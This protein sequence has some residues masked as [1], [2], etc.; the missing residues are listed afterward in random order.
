MKPRVRHSP[1]AAAMLVAAAASA[2]TVRILPQ[3]DSAPIAFAAD[4]IATAVEA[5]GAKVLIGTGGM[6][7]GATIIHLEAPGPETTQPAEAQPPPAIPPNQPE[8]F[9]IFRDKTV[10]PPLELWA[11]G[12]D[13]RGAM[14]AGLE[15][16]EHIALYGLP[17]DGSLPDLSRRAQPSLD[18]RC[19][20]LNMPLPGTRYLGDEWAQHNDWFWDMHYW[21]EFLNMLARNRYNALSLWSAHP[22]PQMVK[23]SK[24][25]EAA[26]LSDDDLAKNQEFFHAILRM[27]GDRGIDTYLVTWNIHVS[28][29]FAE[30]HGI[31][32]AGQDSP[33]VRDYQK[34]CVRELLVQYPEL[35]GIGTCPGENMPM[36]AAEREQWIRD[37]YVKGIEESGRSVPFLHRYW[38]G[39]A[40]PTQEIVAANYEGP[41]YVTLK[42][43]GEHMYSSPEPHFVDEAWTDQVPR[44]Y[45]IVWHL[46]NDDIYALRWG[47]PDFARA[48]LQNCQD[49]YATG[50]LIGSEIWLPGEDYIHTPEAAKHKTWD[51]DFEKQWCRFMLWGRLGYDLTTPMEVFKRHFQVRFGDAAGEQAFEALREASKIAPLVTA[52]HWNYMNGDWYPEGNVGPWNTGAGRGKNWRLTGEGAGDTA[53]FHDVL[54]WMFN[55]TIDDGFVDIPEYT[56]EML[57]LRGQPAPRGTGRIYPP[58]VADLLDQHAAAALQRA[59]A[60]AT[61]ASADNKEFECLN[62]DL[63]AWGVLGHYYAAKIRGACSL[64]WFIASGEQQDQAEAIRH[65]TEALAWWKKLVRVTKRHY[66]PHEV[67]LFGEFD[68]ER[69]L[70]E[71]ERD[72][73]IARTIEPAP[74]EVEKSGFLLPSGE[75][76][77]AFNAA[78]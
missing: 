12:S 19:Y 50:F 52:F 5:A 51:Y 28:P 61:Y 27:A 47:D 73:Q 72:I 67:W 15:I 3:E 44:D 62:S 75:E 11:W 70:P 20:K 60:A 32:D 63:R 34:E 30:A 13:E 29:T 45:D 22:Y 1:T 6:S 10:G 66:A 18:F 24:Y 8:S 40:G 57:P 17:A 59:A 7:P 16:A 64:M 14:Y 74:D 42:Y 25:P 69:Y 38:G 55:H 41:M 53:Q 71:V 2:A 9:V 36:S 39:Q 49:S 77:P 26:T 23:L 76:R 54:E 35:T 31:R 58:E 46:R 78:P 21:R 33:L 48:T 56:G 65:L 37:T 43:N 68:W 4:E